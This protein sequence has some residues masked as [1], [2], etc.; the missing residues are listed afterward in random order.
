M[1]L[2]VREEF[3]SGETDVDMKERGG[4]SGRR[5]AGCTTMTGTHRGPGGFRGHADFDVPVVSR[6]GRWH[7]VAA[8]RL[9]DLVLHIRVDHGEHDGRLVQQGVALVDVP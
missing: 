6:A 9:P 8:L 5:R 1:L 7:V 3:G 4:A 2:I